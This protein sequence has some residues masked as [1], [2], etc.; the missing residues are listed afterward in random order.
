MTAWV[1]LLK[2]N[3][4]AEISQISHVDSSH[5]LKRSTTQFYSFLEKQVKLG[6]PPQGSGVLDTGKDN[7]LF[8]KTETQES[9][10]GGPG[11]F[12]TVILEIWVRSISGTS[13][14][15]IFRIIGTA[16]GYSIT[17]SPSP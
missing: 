2:I 17:G 16:C 9:C 11:A 1:N 13:A 10:L 14:C 4:F 8:F 3:S 15:C 5:L 6:E 12:N 7:T